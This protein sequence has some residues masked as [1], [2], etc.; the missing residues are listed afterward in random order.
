MALTA[1]PLLDAVETPP[2]ALVQSWTAGRNFPAD[3]PLLDLAQAAPGWPMAPEMATHVGDQLMQPD[4]ARYAPILGNPALRSALAQETT[5]IYGGKVTSDHVAITSGCNQA[6]VIAVMALARQGDA[7]MLTEPWYFN[8][9]MTLDMLGIEAER[10][11]CR[12]EAGMI[13]DPAEAARRITARTR[14]IVL[15]TPN[16]PTGAIYPPE[17]LAAF[18]DL[19]ATRGLALILDET[20]RDFLPGTAPPHN[21]FRDAAWDESLVQ[22]Y[23]FSKSFAMPGLRV[24]AMIAGPNVVSAGQ[25]ALDNI[26]ICATQPGQAAA[27]Y[28]LEHLGAWRAEKRQEM[29]RRLEA[30]QATMAPLRDRFPILSA[31]AFFAYCQHPFDASALDIAKQLADDAAIMVM[32]GSA[33]GSGQEGMIRFAFGN[34]APDAARV[35][36]DRLNA[37]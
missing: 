22:L 3:R 26:A 34:I 36:A 25:K 16:N 12:A 17:V 5:R 37:M 33:F 2:V 30:F 24:G 7:V 28:G 1:N 11:P 8:H 13:P 18:R 6:F 9:K 29:A 31:G 15:A 21:L 35:V 23:S 4:A 20:Y 27:L 10:L 14:A 32:P 19:A